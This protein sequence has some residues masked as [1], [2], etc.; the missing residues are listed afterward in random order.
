MTSLLQKYER[1][2]PFYD[3]LDLAFERRRYRRMRPML[4]RGLAGR[5]LDAGVGTGRNIEFYPAGAEMV[6]V[7]LSPPCCGGLS[8]GARCWA[9]RSS[10]G[11]WT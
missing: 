1:I 4:F 9:G 3:L 6:G 5:I 2:A 7:D 10:S 11:R 8:E